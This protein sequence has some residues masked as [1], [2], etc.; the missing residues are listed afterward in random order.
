MPSPDDV[1]AQVWTEAGGAAA[2]LGSV[3]LTG[4]EPGLPSSFRV[5]VAAQASIAAAGLAAAEIWRLR[6]GETQ[7][8]AVDLRHAAVEF[9]SE[10]YMRLAGKPPGPGWDKIAGVY[11]TRDHRKVRIHTNFPQHR[12]GFLK[13]LGCDYERA[14]VAAALMRWD[15]AQFEATAALAGAPCTLMRSPQEWAAHPQAQAVA[16][17]PLIEIERIGEAPP[18]RLPRNPER[19]LSEV[20]VLD[21]TRVIAGPVAGRTLAAHGADVMRITGPHLP[22]LPM[23]DIDTGRGK[24]SASLDLRAAEE[25]ERLASLLSEAQAIVTA[26]RP[27][28][29]D[30]FGFSPQS[31]AEMRPGIVVGTLSAWGRAGPWSSRRGFDSLVQNACGINVA[32]AQALGVEAPKELPAQAL[33]HAAGYLLATG[34][35]LAL[36]RKAEEGGSWHVRVSL[37]RTAHWLAGLG[38]LADGFAV[39]D[40]KPEDVG[41]VLAEME[42]PQGRLTY[43][44]HAARLSATPA[45]WARPPVPLGASAPLWPSAF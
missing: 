6:T 12:D 13:L 29:L 45:H 42:T 38:R 10:R 36:A 17:L 25:C 44:T 43:V 30:R 19:P 34:V 7:S 35:M 8:L 20:R 5:G 28:A 37:A 31:C 27:G 4:A 2:A 41:D 21:L 32:E 33:D 40:P 26:Y 9:R 23:L 22:G 11:G 15:G 14:S 16:T 3:T 39:A 18:R 1:L 24:L